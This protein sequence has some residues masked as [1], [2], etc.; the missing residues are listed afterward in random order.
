MLLALSFG[1]GQAVKATGRMRLLW[2]SRAVSAALSIG[3]VVLAEEFGLI[4]AGFAAI[5]AA[6]VYASASSSRTGR[7]R[8]AVLFRSAPKPAGGR[9]GP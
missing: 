9:G 1:Y 6:A 7:A 8:R 5:I 3:V 2:A 4:G